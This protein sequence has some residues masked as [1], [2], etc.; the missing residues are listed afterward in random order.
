MVILVTGG[1]GFIGSHLTD[2]LIKEG[3]QV[4]VID[5]FLTGKRKNLNP[6]AEF[7]EADIRNLAQIKPYFQGIDYVFHVAAWPRVQTSIDNP[8]ETNEHNVTGALN[9]LVAAR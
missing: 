4:R 2:V 9:V 8:A 7:I 5:N 1:A 6:A 3:H